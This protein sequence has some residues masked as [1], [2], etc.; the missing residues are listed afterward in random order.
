LTFDAAV[1]LLSRLL[2]L[3]QAVPEWRSDHLGICVKSA[4]RDRVPYNTGDCSRRSN[5]VF[6]GG[7]IAVFARSGRF[8][9]EVD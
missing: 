7:E 2:K 4:G 3:T 5:A 8:L 9:T 1:I 6:D